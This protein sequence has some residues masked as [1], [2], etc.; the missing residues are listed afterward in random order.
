M[1]KLLILI[2]AI[3][4]FLHFYPQPEVDKKFEELK[5][6]LLTQFSDATDTKVRLKAD[7]IYT[8]LESQ[9]DTFNSDEIIYLKEITLT[10]RSVKAFYAEYCQGKKSNP[11]FHSTN[12]AKVC[13]TID[14]YQSLL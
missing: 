11:K 2:V 13:K 4:L 8:D 1:K 3:A 14:N 5:N 12:L 10:R 7:K 6:T 9:F